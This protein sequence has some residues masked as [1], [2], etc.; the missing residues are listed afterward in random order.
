MNRYFEM[1][2]MLDPCTV[3]LQRNSGRSDLERVDVIG[4]LAGLGRRH[5]VYLDLFKNPGKERLYPLLADLLVLSMREQYGDND[6][7]LK[8]L[9]DARR[10]HCYAAC[11]AAVM[12][13]FGGALC[14]K[15]NGTGMCLGRV[16][17]KCGG[18][19]H[20]LGERRLAKLAGVGYK[21]WRGSVCNIY[22]LFRSAIAQIQGDISTH[23]HYNLKDS[24]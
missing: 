4:A 9:D 2:S 3:N 14:D 19:G 10:S 12:V 1:L 16:C 13:D 8:P 22:S 23:I 5:D 18:V 11:R 24:A 21:T 7:Q 15:C 6:P 20:G 17:D